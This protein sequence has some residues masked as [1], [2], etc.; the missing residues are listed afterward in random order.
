MIGLLKF[1]TFQNS[2]VGN[3]ATLHS[4]IVALI[5]SG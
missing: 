4:W 5:K 2:W 1:K 3:A